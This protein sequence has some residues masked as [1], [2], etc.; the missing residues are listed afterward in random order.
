MFDFN[1]LKSG[2]FIDIYSSI[3]R[4]ALKA[5]FVNVN[6]GLLYYKDFVTENVS[7]FPISQ[8]KF[9]RKREIPTNYI[10]II[11][12]LVNGKKYIGRCTCDI[13]KRLSAHISSSKYNWNTCKLAEAINQYGKENFTIEKIYEFKEMYQHKANIIEQKFIKRYQTEYPKGYNLSVFEV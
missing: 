10:Y 13:H 12:N 2:D 11:T 6:N 4:I 8:I 7:N 3:C 1:T 9:I 5:R